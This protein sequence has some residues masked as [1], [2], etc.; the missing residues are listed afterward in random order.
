M[1]YTEAEAADARARL[2]AV[3]PGTKSSTSMFTMATSFG[4]ELVAELG[5]DA[6]EGFEASVPRTVSSDSR[7]TVTTDMAE[8]LDAAL[9]GVTDPAI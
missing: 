6:P 3:N 4:Q 2:A 1:A 8:E 5:A 7:M 9:A